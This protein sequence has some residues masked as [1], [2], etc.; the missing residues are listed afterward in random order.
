MTDKVDLQR[1]AFE[2][3]QPKSQAAKPEGFVRTLATHPIWSQRY[4]DLAHWLFQRDQL[5]VPA[6]DREDW[7]GQDLKTKLTYQAQAKNILDL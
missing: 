4:H 3:L 7:S 2:A 5:R 1:A 6:G